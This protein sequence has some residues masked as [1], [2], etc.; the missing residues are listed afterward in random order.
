MF[1]LF[2]KKYYFIV[3]YLFIINGRDAMKIIRWS[4]DEHD[5]WDWEKTGKIQVYGLSG[6]SDNEIENVIKII[7]EV[8]NE[9]TLPLSVKKGDTHKNEDIE[10]LI[11]QCSDNNEIDF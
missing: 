9:F 7:S 5:N 10:Q 2:C 4:L 6:V 1:Y 3:I 11:L 8:I